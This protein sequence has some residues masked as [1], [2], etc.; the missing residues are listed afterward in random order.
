M[1]WVRLSTFLGLLFLLPAFPVYA[2]AP[3]VDEVA[4]RLVCQCGC[5]M[6]LN[7]CTHAECQSREIMLGVIKQRISQGQSAE[8]IVAGFVRQYGE[9]VLA[10]P[11]KRG[12]NLTAWLSPFA[13]LLIGVGIIYFALR[14]WLKKGE[15][16]T[17]AADDGEDDEPYRRRIEQ[18]L[19]EF[20]EKGFR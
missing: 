16:H 6:I 19:K 12:F 8:V 4:N 9:K 3:A 17:V 10:E 20:P 14:K 18:E 2:A 7:N 5:T 15:S 1:R 11:P 13:G